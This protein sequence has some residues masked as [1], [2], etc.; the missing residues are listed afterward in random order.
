MDDGS[1]QIEKISLK[2]RYSPL[3]R[4]FPKKNQVYRPSLAKLKTPLNLKGKRVKI[5]TFLAPFR[6]KM[7]EAVKI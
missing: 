2:R 7:C 4:I 1:N 5:G 3:A 6:P